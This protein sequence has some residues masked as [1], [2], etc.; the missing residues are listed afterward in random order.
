M[1]VQR[2]LRPR[3]GTSST[4][5]MT[6]I[7]HAHRT[8]TSGARTCHLFCLCVR[9][10]H[11]IASELGSRA[12]AVARLRSARTVR[13]RRARGG[14]HTQR[15][16]YAC[17]TRRVP[18]VLRLCRVRHCTRPPA[19]PPLSLSSHRRDRRFPAP[20]DDLAAAS[21]TAL[22]VA[23]QAMTWMAR[24]CCCICVGIVRV[25]VRSRKIC[26]CI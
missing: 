18:R 6:S 17:C 14:Q 3:K 5:H 1:A 2:T 12:A 9:R 26:E 16:E 7:T 19:W 15:W 24:F 20:M 23:L 8:R 22:A 13:E 10:S 21:A 4:T 25:C 11:A